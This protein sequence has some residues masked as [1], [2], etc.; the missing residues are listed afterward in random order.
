MEFLHMCRYS[1]CRFLYETKVLRDVVCN[2]AGRTP[3]GYASLG[4][5]K[6]AF[7]AVIGG[8]VKLVK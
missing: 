7:E 8:L 5:N 3:H 1:A 2:F 4:M 6:K